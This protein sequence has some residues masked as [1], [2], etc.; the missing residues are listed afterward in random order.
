MYLPR[1]V[2]MRIKNGHPRYSAVATV[3]QNAPIHIAQLVVS[4]LGKGIQECPE[5][6]LDDLFAFI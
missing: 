5:P 3:S 2:V 6:N 1:N 4:E